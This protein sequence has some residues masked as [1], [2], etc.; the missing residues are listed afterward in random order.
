MPRFL[1]QRR[2]E[3]RALAS[4]VVEV[5]GNYYSDLGV[6]PLFGRLLTPDDVLPRSGAT[7]QVA[8][9]GYEFWHRA[10]G[11]IHAVVAFAG[12]CEC[13]VKGVAIVRFGCCQDVLH[14]LLK[15]FE[16]VRIYGLV[17]DVDS[18]N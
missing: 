10:F 6:A 17:I 13:Y 16:F 11:G 5:T 7:S 2:S 1:L 18:R 4:R 12:F 9:I 3:H 14:S 15:D 8:V